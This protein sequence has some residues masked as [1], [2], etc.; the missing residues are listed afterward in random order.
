[1]GTYLNPGKYAYEEAVSS[2][3]FVDKTPMIRYLNSLVR[4]RDKY[5]CVSRPRR[6]GKTMAVD[7]LSAYYGRG[8][9]SRDLFQQ[10][11]LAV[12]ELPCASA[13]T[14]PWDTYL[15]AFDVLRVVMT[16]FFREGASVQDAIDRLQQ[17]VVRDIVREYPDAS[18]FDKSDL[19]QSMTDAFATTGRQFVVLIDEWDAPFRVRKGDAAGQR[20]YLDFLRNLLKDKGYVALAY[21][22]GILPIKKYGQH[23][24]LNMFD[25]YSM[26]QPQQ[27]AEY[28]GF[29]TNEVRELCEN[30]GLRFEGMREWY[31]GYRLSNRPSEDLL[32]AGIADTSRDSANESHVYEVYSPLSVVRAARS[33]RLANYWSRTETYEAL[34]E[35]IRMDFDGLRESVALLTDGGHMPVDTSAYQND[36][37][38]FRSR[39]DVLS[40]LVHLGYLGYDDESHEVF[41]PNREILD[42]FKTSTKTDDWSGTFY[43]Y[44]A[45]K[46][47]LKATLAQAENEV[48]RLFEA[49]HDRAENRNRDARSNSDSYKH[50]SCRIESA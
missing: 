7:M 18:Y 4:T 46:K 37:T 33:G 42:E 3:V 34:A 31:D 14:Q 16:D 23:S 27:L 50:H 9:N 25:E 19:A 43:E 24:A 35:Y 29:T 22:T 6:F 47:L 2:A 28:V 21:M 40:L 32:A 44:E 10:M 11:K 8:A 48:A 20:A 45:S 38:T 39:D 15:G 41:V 5:V 49:A 26:T 1:M 12:G 30:R 17:L 36:M 13:V